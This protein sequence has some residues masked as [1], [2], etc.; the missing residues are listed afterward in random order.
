MARAALWSSRHQAGGGPFAA[1]TVRCNNRVD[2]VASPVFEA[3]FGQRPTGRSSRWSV[4]DL[5]HFFRVVLDYW[6]SC[7]RFPTTFERTLAMFIRLLA[8]ALLV[9]LFA[10]MSVPLPMPHRY[11]SVAGLLAPT[12]QAKSKIRSLLDR[13]LGK[14]L[15]EG[16]VKTNGR[17]EATQVD[18][19]AKYP[20]RLVDITVEEGSEVKAGQVVGRVSSPEYEAQLTGGAVQCGARQAVDGRSGIAYRPAQRHAGGGQI[21]FRTR[22]GT[23]RKTDYHAT[24]LRSAPPQLRRRPR[25]AFRERSRSANKPTPRSRA[26]RPRSSASSRFC[27]TWFSSRRERDGC[28]TSSRGTAKWSPPA[29]RS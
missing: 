15:P 1:N 24:D 4:K 23:R 3:A 7:N 26:R 20:G 6:Q 10:A 13:V 28:N 17:I 11:P 14:T 2:C 27:T 8:G 16:I 5:M 21:R 12:A 19:A 22:A 25:Q 9:F 18:V 29:E